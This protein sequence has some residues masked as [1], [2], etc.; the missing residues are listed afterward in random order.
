M[1]YGKRRYVK[2]LRRYSYLIYFIVFYIYFILSDY[3]RNKSFNWIEY[4]VHS[5]FFVLFLS[6]FNWALSDKGKKDKN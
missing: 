6:F 3:F 1:T 2:T 4:G 5:L